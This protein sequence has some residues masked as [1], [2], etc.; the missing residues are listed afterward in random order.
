MLGSLFAVT[1]AGVKLGYFGL[2]WTYYGI[3]YLIYGKQK[4]PVVS[5]INRLEK[6]IECKFNHVDNKSDDFIFFWEHKSSLKYD[7]W[8]LIRDRKVLIET[9][10]KMLALNKLLEQQGQKSL[11]IFNGSVEEKIVEI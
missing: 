1:E 5:Q 3:N 11:L 8:I 2:S 10:D 6:L 7:H 9:P 4:D